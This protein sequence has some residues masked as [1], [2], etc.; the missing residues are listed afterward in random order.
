MSVSE[1][2][3]LRR[4]PD[5][6]VGLPS[7][8]LEEAQRECVAAV[9]EVGQGSWD[10]LD[11]STDPG[12]FGLLVTSGYLLRRVGQGGRFGAELLG[13]GDLLRPWQG[14]G[15]GATLVTE[16]LWTAI[17]DVEVAVLDGEFARCVARFPE[18]AVQL[19]DR[20]M[21]RAR[22]MSI[23]MAIVQQRRVDRRLH[24]LLWHLADRWGKVGSEGTTLRLPLTHS[25]LAELVAA[26]R[27]TVSTALGR[28]VNA[29]KL[30][31]R[32]RDWLLLGE[33]PHELSEL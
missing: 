24:M 22:Q 17:D 18:V 11:E 3:V 1:I 27:P 12:G 8:D 19:V 2:E 21:L 20:A 9:H 29:G 16:P 7:G 5:L 6:A 23:A 14:V 31:R 4:E 15:A 25:I 28:L 32:D 26:R 30:Q 33:P 13:H 10:P